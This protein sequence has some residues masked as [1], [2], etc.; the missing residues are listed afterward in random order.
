M[1]MIVRCNVPVHSLSLA[2]YVF[3]FNFCYVVKNRLQSD[4]C[5]HGYQSEARCR[6]AYSPADATATHFLLL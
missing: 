2:L 3:L 1:Y 4:G 5:W 6:L